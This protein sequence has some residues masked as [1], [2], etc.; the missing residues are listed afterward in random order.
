VIPSAETRRIVL[1]SSTLYGVWD[2]PMPSNTVHFDIDSIVGGKVRDMTTA[3]KKNYL[4]MPNRV[5]VIVVAGINNIGAGEKAE[6]IVKE[7]EE[8]K[9]VV[10]EHSSKWNHTP[11]SYVVFCTVILA[12]KF[13][14]LYVPPSPPEPEVAE[15]TPP[16]SFQ[17]KYEE[18]KKLNDLIIQM[19]RQETL[20]LVRL[21]YHGVKRFKSGTVQHKFDNKPGATP[22]WR[23]VQ[24]FKKLHFTMENKLKIINYISNCFRG[25][26]GE[27]LPQSSGH[28]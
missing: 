15:W 2:H 5:E 10:N 14:S 4:H 27:N 26:A 9:S 6:Q 20:Q 17:N 11:S 25:N 1:A 18:V 8:L 3:L 23:E 19:N 21:D 28:D 13:C 12:P 22:V 7:M 16:A 24:V